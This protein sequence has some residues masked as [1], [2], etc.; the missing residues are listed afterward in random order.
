MK[1]CH[2]ATVCMSDDSHAVNDDW[3]GIRE[4]WFQ[5]KSIMVYKQAGILILGK[6]HK[7]IQ[8]GRKVVLWIQF[9][10]YQQADLNLWTI[11][12]RHTFCF[13]LQKKYAYIESIESFLVFSAPIKFQD[14]KG[15]LILSCILACPGSLLIFVWSR[16]GKILII[17][18][19]LGSEYQR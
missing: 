18:W 16:R 15:S 4:S 17:S 8:A 13:T 3:G 1:S 6:E 11:E 9:I 2:H 5:V 19:I 7:G 10:T 14:W 12:I